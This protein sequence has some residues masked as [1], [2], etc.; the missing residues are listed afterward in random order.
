[1]HSYYLTDP[2]A[3][4]LEERLP[5]PLEGRN[6]ILAECP[7]LLDGFIHASDEEVRAYLVGRIAADSAVRWGNSTDRVS[8]HP[9]ERSLVFW[10]GFLDV[11]ARFGFQKSRAGYEYPQM[12]LRASPGVLRSL[13]DRLADE[14]SSSSWSDP[15]GKYL[16]QSFSSRLD[17]RGE[18]VVA[19]LQLTHG[20]GVMVDP[21]NDAIVTRILEWNETEARVA[22]AADG[23]ALAK[24]MSR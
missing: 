1:M 13:L 8:F 3:R 16:E 6:G 7:S 9:L 2:A 20:A 24:G 19:L 23:Y 10:R 4:L 5:K 12:E 17:V 14:V 21:R 15:G 18:R 11:A 22:A